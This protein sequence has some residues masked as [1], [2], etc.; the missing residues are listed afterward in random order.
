MKCA[1]RIG[2]CCLNGRRPSEQAALDDIR[3]GSE[4]NAPPTGAGK[5]K[6]DAYASI[7]EGNR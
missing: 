7:L 4:L 5:H 6:G 2:G 1:A 3:A